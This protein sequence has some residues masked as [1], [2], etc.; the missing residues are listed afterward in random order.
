M[1]QETPRPMVTP[2][3]YVCA[4]FGVPDIGY[5]SKRQLVGT[6]ASLNRNLNQALI[7]LYCENPT[8]K[9]FEKFE[10]DALAAMKAE[11]D[12]RASAA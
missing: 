10:P 11:R 9:M 3:D 5:I 4:M 6:L 8:H 7:E 2:T 1:I 12:R